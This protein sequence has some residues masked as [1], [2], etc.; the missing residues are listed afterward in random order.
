MT[1]SIC[2]RLE[3]CH[4]AAVASKSIAVGSTVPWVS[5]RGALCTQAATNTA[6]GARAIRAL[7]SGESIEGVVAD[8]LAADLHASARQVHGLDARGNAVAV[9][10]EDCVPWVGDRSKEGITVAGNM[11]AGAGVLEAMAEGFGDATGPL[12]SRLLSALRAGEDAGG[13]KRRETVQSA[14]L[15]VYDPDEPR[16][17]HDLRV[18]ESDDALGELDRIHAAATDLDT[19]WDAEDPPLNRQRH[20]SSTKL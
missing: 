4:G 20:P 19:A 1:F 11:L 9:T 7:E 12:D 8:L 14:A 5:T 3:G 2:A 6:L 10:G 13:D 16:L 17:A 18:D 15:S